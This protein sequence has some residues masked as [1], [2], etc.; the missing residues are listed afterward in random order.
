MVKN[1]NGDLGPRFLESPYLHF[2]IIF[3]NFFRLYKPRQQIETS[4][5]IFQVHDFIKNLY[6]GRVLDTNRCKI[7]IYKK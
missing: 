4:K 7:E 2:D 3:W 5:I 1:T 6:L